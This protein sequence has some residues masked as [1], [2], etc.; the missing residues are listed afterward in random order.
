LRTS[1]GSTAAVTRNQIP[2]SNMIKAVLFDL[3]ETLITE[4]GLN[5]TRASHLG[6]TLGLDDKAFRAEWRTRRPRIVVGQLS[7]VDALTEISHTLAG[8][9]DAAAIQRISQQRIREKTAAYA[10]IDAEVMTLITD[11]RRRG[12]VLAAISN[13]F[14][15]DAVAWSTCALAPEFRC[16]VFSFAEGVA[17][18][19]PEIYLRAVRRLGVD[20]ATTM[21]VGDGGDDE[22][23]GAARAGLRAVR[24]TWFV[25]NSLNFQ[26]CA[27]GA[28]ELAHCQ[29]V[30]KLVDEG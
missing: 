21:F 3:F 18:P 15:E 8:S 14:P 9:V 7:F 12:L 23:A 6:E 11:L 5:P 16:A 26:S 2:I 1:D 29:D 13:C 28:L 4:S 30:L 27:A 10:R 17:K 24:S 25:R 20:P 19:A 22:V